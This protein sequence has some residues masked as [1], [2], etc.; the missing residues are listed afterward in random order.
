MHHPHHHHRHQSAPR[1]LLAA[2]AGVS[3]SSPPCENER[4]LSGQWQDSR[5]GGAAAGC[6]QLPSCLPVSGDRSETGLWAPRGG[7]AL[8]LISG[9][10]PGCRLQ[11]SP[12]V[13][14]GEGRSQPLAA[15]YIDHRGKN[16]NLVHLPP[17]SKNITTTPVIYHFSLAAPVMRRNE[18]QAR[19]GC[20]FLKRD[21][22]FIILL[23]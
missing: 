20:A 21:H 8:I 16:H 19:G 6:P 5:R 23:A 1:F 18:C 15:D 2:P 3:A 10:L 7:P 22:S 12:R 17:R 14:S 11:P 13:E 9:P 4:L